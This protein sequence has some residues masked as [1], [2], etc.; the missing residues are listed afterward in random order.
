MGKIIQFPGTTTPTHDDRPDTSGR[1]ISAR[2]AYRARR[3]DDDRK[4]A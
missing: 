1:R 2:F 4:A 3:S